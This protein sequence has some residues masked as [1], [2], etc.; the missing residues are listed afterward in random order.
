MIMFGFGQGNK[1]HY[2][3]EVWRGST[4]NSG[5]FD[6]TYEEV[7]AKAYEEKSRPGVTKVIVKKNGKQIALL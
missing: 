6:G 5:A 4:G 2:G 7:M 3:I 1:Q